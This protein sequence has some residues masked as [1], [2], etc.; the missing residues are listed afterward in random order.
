MAV[1]STEQHQLSSTGRGRELA[2]R[3]SSW[4]CSVMRRSSIFKIPCSSMLLSPVPVALPQ[5]VVLCRLHQIRSQPVD[6]GAHAI[7]QSGKWQ[8]SMQP[9]SNLLSF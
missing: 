5:H 3:R 4:D 2:A 1:G 6:E 8:S 7:S 9:L